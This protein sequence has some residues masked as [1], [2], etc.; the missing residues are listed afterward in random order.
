MRRE[1]KSIEFWKLN[2]GMRED[3]ELYNVGSDPECMINL[4]NNA[5]YNTLKRSMNEQLYLEL[6]NQNDPR[7][8][9]KGDIFDNYPYANTEIKDFYNRIMKGELFRKNAGWVDSTDFENIDF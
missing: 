5:G 2:F 9:S 3:E 4:A 7:V 1:E 8:Y 6:L